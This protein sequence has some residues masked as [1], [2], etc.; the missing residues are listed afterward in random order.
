M[1][2]DPRTVRFLQFSLAGFF[3]GIGGGLYA[4]TY[5]I[6]TFDA[7][8]SPLSANA[9]LMA[10]IGG[11]MVFA[12]P[13]LGAVLITLL[14]SG[15]SLMSNSWL[16]YVG[17]LFIA[18]VTFA[19]TGLAG[20]IVAHQPV[21]R[22]GRLSRLLVPYLRLLPA[23]IA[24]LAGFVGLVELLSFLTIGAEQGKR[25]VLFGSPV[26]VASAWPWVTAGALLLVGG[27]WLVKEARSFSRVWEAVIDDVQEA[28]T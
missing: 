3:A 12:G 16:I 2:Y 13:V 5:E 8:A 14:Q 20:I 19:P 22:A 18:M 15:V 23:A 28:R 26:N 1:G 25:L 21:W 24:S 7:V 17:V 6:V 4:I 27:I 11:A 9:L 10:Y